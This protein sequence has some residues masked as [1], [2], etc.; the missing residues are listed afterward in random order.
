KAKAHIFDDYFID[1][2]VPEDY[3][4]FNNDIFTSP[5]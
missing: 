1:I 5:E 3:R 2:G 4:R